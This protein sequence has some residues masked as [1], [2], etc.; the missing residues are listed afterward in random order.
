MPLYAVEVC[1]PHNGVAV[2]TIPHRVWAPS[3]WLAVREIIRCYGFTKAWPL[4]ATETVSKDK[5]A[6]AA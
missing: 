2:Y 5:L 4:R 1:D 6:S 3:K